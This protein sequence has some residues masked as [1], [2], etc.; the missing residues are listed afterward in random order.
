METNGVMC[1]RVHVRND[2]YSVFSQFNNMNLPGVNEFTEHMINI[3][4]G[5]WLNKEDIEKIVDLIN[6]YN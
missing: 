3:P 4:V 1:D 2:K 6:S 5:W